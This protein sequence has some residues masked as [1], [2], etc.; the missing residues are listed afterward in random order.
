[1]AE[2]VKRLTNE[3]SNCPPAK[4]PIA[5]SNID[6]SIGCTL[7]GTSPADRSA[8]SGL[9]ALSAVLAAENKARNM[10]IGSIFSAAWYSI[11]SYMQATAFQSHV[12]PLNDTNQTTNLHLIKGSES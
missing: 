7:S 6:S 12:A 4:R 2:L 5:P 3:S 9:I 1:M 8:L 10:L 11:R